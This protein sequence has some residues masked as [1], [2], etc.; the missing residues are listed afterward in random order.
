[1]KLLIKHS[2]SLGLLSVFM[3]FFLYSCK[4]EDRF[5]EPLST[6][7]ESLS[8]AQRFSPKQSDESADVVYQWYTFMTTLQRPFAQPAVFIQARAFAYIGVGLFESVQPGIKG[9]SSF[10]PK[11]Y[12]MPAMPKPD[13]SKDYLWRASANAALA[14]MFKQFLASLSLADRASID[15]HEIAIYNQLKMTT[16]QEVLKRS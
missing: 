5:S 3:F 8:T 12:Q 13:N 9:G 11:L 15:A 7:A 14:S 1:M 2:F 6:D 10:S 16:S 4:K